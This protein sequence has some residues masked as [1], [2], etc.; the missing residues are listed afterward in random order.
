METPVVSPL[1]FDAII[2]TEEDQICDGAEKSYHL[3]V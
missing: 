3:R 2:P 1:I